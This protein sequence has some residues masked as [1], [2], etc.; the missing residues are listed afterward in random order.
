MEEFRRFREPYGAD[1]LH[2]ELTNLRNFDRSVYTFA[3]FLQVT[4]GATVKSPKLGKPPTRDVWALNY[5]S[6]VGAVNFETGKSTVEI[7]KATGYKRAAMSQ[8]LN[9]MLARGT[10]RL[11]RR[12]K[13]IRYF[14]PFPT[15]E[16]GQVSFARDESLKT[17]ETAPTSQHEFERYRGSEHRK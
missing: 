17:A 16:Q 8:T 10:V 3:R 12:G 4:G 2:R 7:A 14:L 6:K 1:L 15:G 13:R 5:L 9:L 11:E